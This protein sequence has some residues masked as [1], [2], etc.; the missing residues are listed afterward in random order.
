MFRGKFKAGDLVLDYS[1]KRRKW[2]VKPIV[3]VLRIERVTP[4]F[5]TFYRGWRQKI[6]RIDPHLVLVSTDIPWTFGRQFSAFC[7][8]GEVC[9]RSRLWKVMEV[10]Y[11]FP[12]RFEEYK[13]DF[14]GEVYRLA[15]DYSFQPCGYGLQETNGNET[16]W[17]WSENL[18]DIVRLLKKRTE[19]IEGDL[20]PSDHGLP[21]ELVERNMTIWKGQAIQPAEKRLEAGDFLAFRPV[22]SFGLVID[23]FSRALNP[24]EIV[25]TRGH[26]VDLSAIYQPPTAFS[27]EVLKQIQMLCMAISFDEVSLWGA[28][29][30][31]GW[32]VQEK[33]LYYSNDG[34]RWHRKLSA[35]LQREIDR[36]ALTGAG[37]LPTVN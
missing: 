3:P 29:T 19:R 6:E 24:H 26:V 13:D 20:A 37:K 15:K 31:D 12:S 36:L 34:I 2:E 21:E 23:S 14:T 35:A 11:Q 5:Y 1:D 16:A 9:Y 4:L 32:P 25:T 7:E 33:V 18:A 27:Q 22:A 28:F 8:L 30:T 17:F 10:G